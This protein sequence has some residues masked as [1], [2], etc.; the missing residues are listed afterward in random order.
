MFVFSSVKFS[1]FVVLDLTLWSKVAKTAIEAEYAKG[2]QVTVSAF[3]VFVAKA[4]P[5]VRTASP[6]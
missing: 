6:P 4:A 1:C 3:F 5:T 2:I